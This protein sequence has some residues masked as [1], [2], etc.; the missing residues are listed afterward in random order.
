M[1][2][3]DVSR[4][5]FFQLFDSNFN[6]L[7]IVNRIKKID[8]DGL[9]NLEKLYFFGSWNIL[10]LDDKLTRIYKGTFHGLLNLREG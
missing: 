6:D 10:I 8:N 3:Y 5:M 9:S 4:S 7:A 2:C 1:M